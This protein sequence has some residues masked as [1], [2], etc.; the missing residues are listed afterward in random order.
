MEEEMEI[1]F[2]ICYQ[3]GKSDVKPFGHAVAMLKGLGYS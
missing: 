2:L 1:M 3:R